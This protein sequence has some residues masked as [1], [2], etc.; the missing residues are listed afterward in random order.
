MTLWKMNWK[1]VRKAKYTNLEL[2]LKILNEEM[3][4]ALKE[5]DDE[6][7]NVQSINR[8]LLYYTQI[9]EKNEN[10]SK[11]ERTFQKFKINQEHQRLF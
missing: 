8:D 2:E 3:Q 9:V 11:K 5:K 4:K 7:K 10:V 1:S 6:N